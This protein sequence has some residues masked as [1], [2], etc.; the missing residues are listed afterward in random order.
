MVN[1]L[2][3]RYKAVGEDD[4]V[5]EREGLWRWVVKLVDQEEAGIGQELEL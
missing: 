1:I 2:L 5:Q 3:K 4:H